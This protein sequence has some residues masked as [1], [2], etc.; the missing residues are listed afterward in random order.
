[1]G[2]RRK[3]MKIVIVGDGKVGYTLT[4]QLSEE[5]HDIVVIDSNRTVLA[6]LAETFDVM[7]VHGNGAS[8][9]TPLT[10]DVGSSDLLI[11][12]TC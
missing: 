4:E 3:N 8:L 6:A 1:M 7:V 10:A 9:Q 12:G 11:A 2:W 5:G